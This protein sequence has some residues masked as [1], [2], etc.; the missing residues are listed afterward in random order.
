MMLVKQNKTGSES[1]T[2]RPVTEWG[3]GRARSIC[4]SPS[5]SRSSAGCPLRSQHGRATRYQV[6]RGLGQVDG[7][8]RRDGPN[9][10]REQLA[11][12]EKGSLDLMKTLHN[13]VEL[14]KNPSMIYKTASLEKRKRL[15]TVRRGRPRHVEV[16]YRSTF[17]FLAG[18][19]SGHNDISGGKLLWRGVRTVKNRAGHLFRLAAFSLHHSLTPLGSYLRRMKA[20]L[21][22]RAATT[23]TAH[24]IAVIFYTMVKN[25]VE[26]DESIWASRDAYREKRLEIKLKRQAKQLGYQLVPIEHKAA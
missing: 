11:E 13:T 17:C 2:Y 12:S 6:R 18:T 8:G 10:L 22:P 25:Q 24:K 26:Y 5:H 23:A 4:E 14:A 20:K 15:A 7:H 1:S 16:A 3:I 9:E 21:G 19:L